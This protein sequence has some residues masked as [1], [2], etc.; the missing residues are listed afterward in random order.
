MPQKSAR[1]LN[2]KA[3]KTEAFQSGVTSIDW[4]GA[5]PFIGLHLGCFLVIITGW[6]PIALAV[7]LVTYVIRGF[8]ITAGYHRYFSHRSYKM[9][10]FFQFLIALVGTM[11]VQ[12]GP[13]WWASH[14]RNHHRYSDTENDVH[15]PVTQSFWWSHIGWVMDAN[16]YRD[17]DKSLVSDFSKYPELRWL[18]RWCLLPPIALAVGLWG[19]GSLLATLR[20]AWGTSGLQMLTWAFFI[21]TVV[22]HHVTFSVNSVAHI[23]G[24][25]RFKTKDQSRNNAPLALITMGEGWHNNH[26]RFPSSERQGIYWWEVDITHGI[27]TML[28]W[29]GLVQS[30]RA[31]SKEMAESAL[32]KDR[33]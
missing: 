7:A 19:L 33:L 9:G 1:A 31:T 5:I 14:H 10:R 21:S 24:K 2:Y 29:L 28:S 18:D 6:S 25:Q 30:L 11:A 4:L 27:L 26:H 32:T 12:M 16:S 22:L 15:S 8:S 23:F 17:V 13:L 3:S 20:P